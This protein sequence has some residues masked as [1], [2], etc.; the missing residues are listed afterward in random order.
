MH[1]LYEQ[2]HMAL[3]GAAAARVQHALLGSASVCL[4]LLTFAC[5]SSGHL[6][7][8]QRCM[9]AC[10]QQCMTTCSRVASAALNMNVSAGLVPVAFLS[11]R[12]AEALT[13]AL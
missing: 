3:A 9:H 6:W 5:S 1:K 7:S 8:A 13:S 2:S 11:G 4:A 12:Y 10:I